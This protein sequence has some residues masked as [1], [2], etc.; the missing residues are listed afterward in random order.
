MVKKHMK[1]GREGEETNG[2][3]SQFNSMTVKFPPFHQLIT[4]V[5]LFL[6]RT[7]AV[8]AQVL[9][10][11]RERCNDTAKGREGGKPRRELFPSL[12]IR[13]PHTQINTHPKTILY[14]KITLLMVGW[15]AGL[16][17]AGE[18]RGGYEGGV[19]GNRSIASATPQ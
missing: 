2:S 5:E 16:A 17:V 14:D 18:R 15:A 6:I 19:E 3:I 10:R 7:R 8:V 1:E 4:I 12:S 13:I 11:T 9:R